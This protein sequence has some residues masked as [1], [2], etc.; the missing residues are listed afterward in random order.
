MV[1]SFAVVVRF[2]CVMDTCTSNEHHIIVVK[3]SCRDFAPVCRLVGSGIVEKSDGLRN[4]KCHPF[5][6]SVGVKLF[7]GKA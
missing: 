6:S 3:V 1:D 5:H 7:V 4:I 2:A